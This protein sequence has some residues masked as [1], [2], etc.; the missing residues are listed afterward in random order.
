MTESGDRSVAIVT[1]WYPTPRVPFGGP[2]V[3]ELVKAVADRCDG[4][5]VYHLDLWGLPQDEERAA[6]IARTQRRLQPL[7]RTGTRG[8]GGATVHYAPTLLPNGG[9]WAAQARAHAEWLTAALGGEPLPQPVVHAHVGIRGAYAA[10]ENARPDARVYVT[11]H[12]SFLADVL[13]Q[14]AARELYDEVIA[15]STRFFVVGRNLVDLLAAVY[16]H[17]AGK[18]ELVAN[19]IDFDVPRKRPVDRIRRWIAIAALTPRKRVDYLIQG[20]A[21]CRAADP[22]LRLTV[23]GTGAQEQ[24][25]RELAEALGVADAVDFRGAVEPTEIPRIMAEHDLFVHTSRHE[26]FGVVVVEAL[27][28]GVPVLA[29]RCGGPEEL[30]EGIE[31]AAGGMIDVDD[32]PEALVKGYQELARRFPAGLDLE[33]AREHLRGRY[34]REAVADHHEAIWFGRPAAPQE[35]R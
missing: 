6:L 33:S 24:E 23:V 16:P 15:R 4:V 34:S 19:P 9:D 18:V 1:P 21:R 3:Q 17:H 26:T 7:A 11:E 28:A 8:A 13:G 27:A 31:D 20:F 25:L 30:L 29:T 32:S 2:F 5:T 10:L 12:A 14:P 22:G 35:G